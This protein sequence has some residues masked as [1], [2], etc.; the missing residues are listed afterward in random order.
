MSIKLRRRELLSAGVL[1]GAWSLTRQ[2]RA[3]AEAAGTKRGGAVSSAAGTA[4]PTA[5][6]GI[7]V[8]LQGGPSHQDLFDLKPEAPAEYR[9]EFR[10]IATSV[11]GVE[12]CEHLPQLARSARDY[13]ILRGVTHNLADHGIGTRYVLTGNRP[14]PLVRYPTFGSVVSRE[15]PTADDL[16]PFVAIAEDPVGPGFLGSRYGALATGEHPS[17]NQPFS[18]RGI[19]VSDKLTIDRLDRRRRLA[20]DVDTAFRGFE[21]LDDAVTGLDSFAR[22]A[23]DIITSTRS[24]QAF[25]LERERA[26]VLARFSS[27]TAGRSLLLAAR[28]IEA[29]VRFVTVG[30]DGWDTHNNNFRELKTKLLPPLDK[31][32]AALFQTLKEKGLTESTTVLVTGEFGR[33][34]KVNG[35]SGRD[36]WARAMFCL[37][38]GGGVQ[39]GRVLGASDDKAAEPADKGYT[40][41]DVAATFYRCLGID[42]KHEYATDAGR[43]IMLVRDGNTIEGV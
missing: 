37:L 19:S 11:P 18:V 21:K 29:G 13:T 10:P 33:T 15:H 30:L 14:V 23:H 16:P 7:L 38:A 5:R 42:P 22:Q 27:D 36:H 8:H 34:P 35:T 25:E 1:G 9:G 20:I 40:P 41:D 43:P 12:I 39:G 31:S 17:P 24:R 32:L 26:D 6:S 4:L 28:L 3:E 2:L